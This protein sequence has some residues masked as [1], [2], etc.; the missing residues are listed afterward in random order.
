[1]KSLEANLLKEDIRVVILLLKILQDILAALKGLESEHLS[2]RDMHQDN[3]MLDFAGAKVTKEDLDNKDFLISVLDQKRQFK[4]VLID[5][6]EA[7]NLEETTLTKQKGNTF[8]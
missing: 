2:H 5:F 1:M 4:I 3:F 7:K 6:G 8:F